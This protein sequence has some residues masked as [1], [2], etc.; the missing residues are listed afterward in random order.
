MLDTTGHK[1]VLISSLYVHIASIAASRRQGTSWMSILLQTVRSLFVPMKGQF[2]LRDESAAVNMSTAGARE[3]AP[4]P[5][6]FGHHTRHSDVTRVDKGRVMSD[7]EGVERRPGWKRDAG[8]N[9]L[10]GSLRDSSSMGYDGIQAASK[11]SHQEQYRGKSAVTP[12]VTSARAGDIGTHESAETPRGDMA[13][14]PRSEGGAMGILRSRRE[15]R[16]QTT[17]GAVMNAVVGLF[18]PIARLCGASIDPDPLALSQCAD[19]KAAIEAMSQLLQHA[20][21]ED[22]SGRAVNYIPVAL[23]SLVALDMY[24]QEYRDLVQ[25]ACSS[26][27]SPFG[28]ASWSVYKA[29]HL[30]GAGQLRRLG[31]SVGEV[32]SFNLLC[33]SQ[34]VEAALNRVVEHYRDVISTFT[35]PPAYAHRIRSLVAKLQ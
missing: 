4:A 7:T 29:Q 13:Y 22:T 5:P 16:E 24:L 33:L 21:V 9:S 12:G 17:V 8:R 20:R 32:V 2:G 23:C 28:G 10:F 14:A 15:R 35:F 31:R 3:A 19:T 6:T 30:N 11:S 34:C 18:P 26:N 27:R 1:S 25:R